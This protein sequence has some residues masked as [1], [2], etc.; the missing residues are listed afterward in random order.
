MSEPS[1]TLRDLLRWLLGITRPV[2]PPLLLSTLLRIINLS[3][4][5]ALF[6]TAASGM[7]RI[8]GG[9]DGF[10]RTTLTLVVLSLLK[11]AAFYGEQ[12]T[13]HYVAFK[14]LELLR[15]YV[16]GRLWPKAPAIISHSRSGD[17]LTSLT[18][19]VDRIEVVYAHTFAPVVSAYVVGSGA[20]VVA[21]VWVGWEPIAVAVVCLAISLLIVPYLGTRAAMNSTRR[22]LARRRDLTHYVS[23]TIHGLDEVL[24]Y[25]RGP[26]RLKEMDAVGAEVARCSTIPRDLTGIRRGMNIFLSLVA[27]GSIVALGWGTLAPT[28]I[29]GL[30]AAT[31]RS[32]EGPRGIEDATGFLDHS[33]AAARRLWEISHAPQRVH[34]GPQEYRPDGAPRVRFSTV[35]YTY[36]GPWDDAVVPGAPVTGA[37]VEDITLDIP[38][39]GHTILVGRSGSGKSTLVQL[40]QRY[41]D[42]TAGEVTIDDWPLGTFTLDSLRRSVVSVSQKNQ[43]LQGTIAENLRL[44]VPEANEE[45]LWQAL[46]AAGLTAEIR[47]MPE[48]LA[49]GVGQSSTALSGGQVQR[50]CL[51]RALLMQPRVLIL[52]EFTANLNVDLE[53]QIR[54]GLREAL[55]GATI[56]EVTHRLRATEE[57]DLIA[58]LDRGRLLAAG[59]PQEIS[60]EHIESLFRESLPTV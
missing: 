24:G 33:L 59:T 30:A 23:D 31:L 47:A 25:A 2:H 34:D 6:A 35:S 54:A 14:A 17:I 15:G 60:L 4:D 11:A 38:A 28:V 58:V 48:G 42:P 20:S 44:G 12:F 10:G 51:A 9:G 56:I 57:A 1:P 50:L 5:L 52:D 32:F 3:L 8:I 36:P 27:A 43:L 49:T 22:V 7:V 40:L 29:A 21:G 13:G 55:P 19:D 45:Q 53:A 39:G 18:R 37:A 16:F 46:A 41:D 26:E